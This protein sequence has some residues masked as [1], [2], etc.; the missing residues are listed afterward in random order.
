MKNWNYNSDCRKEKDK[1]GGCYSANSLIYLIKKDE[2]SRENK[3]FRILLP[4]ISHIHDALEANVTKP[5]RFTVCFKVKLNP[6]YFH[7]PRVCNQC[8]ESKAWF[9]GKK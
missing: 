5:E 9:K 4:F 3:L 8:S 2:K 6:S 1:F 7:A